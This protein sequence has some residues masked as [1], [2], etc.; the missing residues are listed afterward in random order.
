MAR[1]VLIDATRRFPQYDYCL[2]QGMAQSGM[3]VEFLTT[4]YAN[5]D[6]A[7][8]SN[9]VNFFFRNSNFLR[10]A[11]KLPVSVHRMLRAF[12]Y[13]WDL[14]RLWRR[15]SRSEVEI[16]HFM[17]VIF[18]SATLWLMRALRKRGVRVFYTAHNPFIYHT[19]SHRALAQSGAMYQLVDH[20]VVLT[21]YVAR[22]LVNVLGVVRHKLTVIPIINF[23]LVLESVLSEQDL[24][25]ITKG[26]ADRKTILFFGAILP[27]KGLDV[28]I[29]AFA[30]A[31]PRLP[32]TCR[33]SIAGPCR[34][35]WGK[36]QTLIDRLGISPYVH[37]ERRYIPLREMVERLSNAAVIVQPH[38]RASQ[39][40]SVALAFPLGIPVVSSDSGGLPEQVHDGVDGYVFRSGD[41]SALSEALIR[42]FEGEDKLRAMRRAALKTS[43]T[44]MNW[45]HIC[46]MHRR[47]YE[48]AFDRIRGPVLNR[49]DAG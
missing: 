10:K 44:T 48:R 3:D 18:P 22:Q 8:L 39:S 24:L 42:V 36:Y 16:V 38:I 28:L 1:I 13:F 12:E 45:T 23:A 19:V 21:E 17:F 40:A 43:E 5:E 33:L 27:Y 4:E 35:R 25:R 34:D 11:L 29:K 26:D 32:G 30:L 31:R 20:I 14:A 41:V 6:V 2:L 37:A 9:A 46:E 7:S 15:L 47:I 49:G